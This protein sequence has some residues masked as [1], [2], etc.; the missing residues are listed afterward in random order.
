MEPALEISGLAK[1]Y[2][3]V[4]ALGGVS[5]TVAPGEILGYLG[6]NGAGKTTTLRILAGLV[7][8]DAGRFALLGDAS[9]RAGVRARVGYLPGELRLPPEMTGREALDHY[10]GFRRGRPPAL[11]EPLAAAFGLSP[12]DLGRRIKTLSHGTRQKLGLVAALEHDPDLLLLDE[13]SN[14]LDPLVQRT[15]RE[16]LL[17]RARAGR[18]VLLSSHTL[19]EVEAVCGRVAIL[20]AGAIVAVESIEGLRARAVR[21]ARVRFREAAPAAL[22]GLPGVARAEV[23]GV[24]AT[25]WLRGDPNPL[26]RELARHDVEHLALPEPRLEDIFLGYYPGEAAGA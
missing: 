20:R 23:A 18:A 3:R 6:P 10:A 11:R 13:P 17:Q 5:L 9:G 14:G 24:E 4:V 12:R 8:A 19:A 26:L 2:G 7:R 15:L 1:R 25:L 22:A 16:V 21:C